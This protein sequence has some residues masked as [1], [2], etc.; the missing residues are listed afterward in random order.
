MAHL[1]TLTDDLNTNLKALAAG[2]VSTIQEFKIRVWNNRGGTVDGITDIE[3]VSLSLQYSPNQNN[4]LIVQNDC[5]SVR[6]TY[7]AKAAGIVSESY[8]SFPIS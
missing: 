8:S 7:S 5:F 2:S 3:N 1:I 6:C 4:N